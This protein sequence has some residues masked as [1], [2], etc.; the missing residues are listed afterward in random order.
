MKKIISI[1]IPIYNAE[2]YLE[3]C[4]QSVITQTYKNLEIILINDGSKDNSKKICEEFKNKDS[5]I[6]LINKENE[7]VSTAR[8]NGIDLITGEY[9]LFVDSDDW[10][11]KEM[12]EILLNKIEKEKTDIVVCGYNNYYENKNELEHIELK[13]YNKSF[14]YLISDDNTKYGGFPWNK[15]MKKE[16]IKNKFDTDIYYY[17]NLLFFLKNSNINTKYSVVKECLYNYCINDNSAVHTKKYSKRKTTTLE[18]IQ[19]CIN[20]LPEENVDAHKYIY[21]NSYYNNFYLLKKNKMDFKCIEK[22][23]ENLKK[24]FYELIISKKISVIKKI[25]LCIYYK[26]S[27]LYG[28]IVYLK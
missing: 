16:F 22:Y 5:R 13:E 2:K 14:N 12:C 7:G 19:R 6:R 3:R 9:V 24:Y 8:N 4:L 25:K 27:F 11:E 1:I 21:I 10:L 26:M 28:V 15:L 23:K 20:F 18:A 17:E